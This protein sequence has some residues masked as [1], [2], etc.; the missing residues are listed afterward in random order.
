MGSDVPPAP[1]VGGEEEPEAPPVGGEEDKEETDE[2]I[3]LDELLES[4]KNEIEGDD[5][6]EET[7]DETK[8]SSS[9]IG[10]KVGGSDNKQPAAAAKNS[11]KIESGGASKDGYPSGDAKTEATDA[12][13]AKRPNQG[14]NVTKTNLSTPSKGGESGPALKAAR[15]NCKGDF[16]NTAK[17]NEENEALKTQLNEAESTIKFVK[18]Q[19]N[20]INLLNA[21]LLY[22][23]KLFKGF[24]MSNEQKMRIVE[25]FDLSQSV[26]EVKMTF[27]NISKSLNF[28]DSQKK[29]AAASPSVQSITEGLAS[30][31]IGST[32]PSSK[33]IISESRS[34][35]VSQ[36]QKLAG[37]KKK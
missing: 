21:K 35:M 1:E 3:N 2:T 27:A 14:A 26:R 37:I 11:S 20:E 8:L 15:P 33:E 17:L 23:N 13:E 36:F 34:A 7:I 29:P 32:K 10:G 5:K 24:N 28:G 9:A 12:T 30:R 22:T 4:L 18:S 31:Q 25:M 16:E 6:K 19:L